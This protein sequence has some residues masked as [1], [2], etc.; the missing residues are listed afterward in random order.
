M[1]PWG[2]RRDSQPLLALLL[3]YCW[4]GWGFLRVL[5]AIII[6]RPR[7]WT[8]GAR[9]PHRTESAWTDPTLGI[10]LW[11]PWCGGHASSS[12]CHGRVWDPSLFAKELVK[13]FMMTYQQQINKKLGIPRQLLRLL[14]YSIALLG[15]HRLLW[16]NRCPL[17]IAV[18]TE[19]CRFV[20]RAHLIEHD[21]EGP[22]VDLWSD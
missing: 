20:S 18:V 12:L 15:N 4:V 19:F 9:G 17:T 14:P 11:G 2:N 1:N 21:S 13:L 10:R 5:L 7:L 6:I 8:K 3:I 22:H 16:R